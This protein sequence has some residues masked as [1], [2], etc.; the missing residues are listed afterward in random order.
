[1]CAL[2]A[3]ACSAPVPNI[4]YV[5]SVEQDGRHFIPPALTATAR[6]FVG[7][8][9]T[10]P[11]GPAAP[12]AAGLPFE[13]GADTL[14]PD[15]GTP[16]RRTASRRIGVGVVV[17][18]RLTGP[19]GWEGAV[20]LSRG[21]SRYVL[22]QGLGV[23]VDPI[24]IAFDTDQLDAEAGLTLHGQQWH[25]VQ[26]IF[27]VGGGV[28]LTRTKTRINSA[29]LNVSN[30][31]THQQEFVYVSVGLEH[32]VGRAKVA[33]KSRAYFHRDAGLSFQSGLAVRY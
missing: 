9:A 33:L 20:R 19:L 14:S 1:M 30:R 24:T 11:A 32:P 29:L 28:S 12:P 10:P 5:V 3:S 18:G 8:A 31:S 13:I 15:S 27:G 26:P 22:P 7:G 21:Q 16:Y 23:L 4:D 2:F 6:A 17:D 25:R